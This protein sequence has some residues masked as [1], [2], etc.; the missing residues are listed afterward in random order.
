MM[1]LNSYTSSFKGHENMKKYLYPIT[2]TLLT[3]M[4]FAL[5]M[6]ALIPLVEN[7]QS[8]TKYKAFY[9]T[10]EEYDVLFC[11]DSHM[12][13]TAYTME[14]WKNHGIRAYNIA[15]SAESM[16]VT[17]Y[18]IKN[19]LDHCDP[20][21]IVIDTFFT[22]NNR[23]MTAGKEMLPHQYFDMLPLSKNKIEAVN[24]L[25]DSRET[26]FGYLF[27]F[28]LYHSRWNELERGDFFP[29]Y[30]G[31]GGAEPLLASYTVKPPS[32]KMSK[33]HDMA[34]RPEE[35]LGKIKSLC[36]EKG[37]KLI[38]VMNP[39]AMWFENKTGN[40]D[41]EKTF[42]KLGIEFID[43]RESDLVDIYADS[44]D[45]AH[46]NMTGA[47]KITDF[48]GKYLTEHSYVPDPAPCDEALWNKNYEY[49]IEKK[50]AVFPMAAD[51][52]GV[53]SDL[54]DPDFIFDLTLRKGYVPEGTIAL[55]LD[56]ARSFDNV[57][58]S[59]E[60]EADDD[61]LV[62]I[63]PSSGGDYFFEKSYR[64]SPSSL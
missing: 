8:Y 14:L 37:I 18:V 11:G 56:N 6:S 13:N 5:I 40:V 53:L 46:L 15:N 27:D 4:I 34:K 47:R 43:L 22:Y 50:K 41:F 62:R 17:Y 49:Y 25:F 7:K 44:G 35:Y 39:Y 32:G 45:V 1:Q 31:F 24:C 38:C 28:S 55:M 63:R 29:E 64:L 26:R 16:P 57:N 52:A 36:D 9:D 30:N 19:A 2:E 61:I 60:G 21:V 59:A 10:P 33:K 54:N 42:S 3:L 20:K 23:I 58:I 48:Y 51:C 12:M